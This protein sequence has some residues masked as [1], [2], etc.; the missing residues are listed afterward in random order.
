MKHDPRLGS[1]LVSRYDMRS[2][3][4]ILRPRILLAA[5]LAIGF[6]AGPAEAQRKIEGQRSSGRLYQNPAGQALG[7]GSVVHPDGNLGSN[8]LGQGD[9]LDSSLEVGSGGRN[10]R[11]PR[12][13]AY[14][15]QNLQARNLVVTNSVTGGRGFRGDVGYL[16]PGDFAGV[17]GDEATYAF[18][19][20]SALSSLNFL[21]SDRALDPFNIAQ[22]V[23]VFQYRRDFTSL[24]EVNTIDGIRRI[25]DAEIRL[26]R[27]NSALASRS[28]VSTAT[29]PEDIGIVAADESTRL[30]A[31][32]S[33][34]RGVQ[35]RL[36]GS[37]P[38]KDLYGEALMNGDRILLDQESIVPALEPFRSVGGESSSSVPPERI[39]AQLDSSEAYERIMQRVYE[40]YE[41]QEDVSIDAAS[42]K[43]MRRDFDQLESR[44]TPVRIG[45]PDATRPTNTTDRREG[46]PGERI[47]IPGMVELIAEEDGFD[48]ID[49]G[50][51]SEPP[52]DDDVAEGADEAGESMAEEEI[53]PRS[54]DELVRSLSHGTEIASVV[55]PKMSARIRQLAEQGEEAMRDGAYFRAEDRFTLALKLD[56]GNPILEAGQ[57]NAQIGAGLYRSAT[58]TLTFMYRRHPEMIDVEW[59]E[60]VRPTQTR[61]LLAADDIRRMIERDYEG[62]NGLGLLIAYIGRQL[63]D[64][65]LIVEGLDSIKDPRILS[66]V[67]KIRGIW[68]S[69]PD[70]EVDGAE[71]SQL[72]ESR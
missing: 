40:K 14:S 38:S 49:S 46:L 43:R 69:N 57:A 51:A 16:A 64:R 48:G 1:V 27:A 11:S 50:E 30:Q 42:L 18:D 60:S 13:N 24:P 21:S 54:I 35:Y 6:A 53:G 37:E 45:D 26:D 67:P 72:E 32:S 20:N 8:A 61:L 71:G 66:M 10:Y 29:S 31:S 33:T 36:F 17:T 5:L 47:P 3:L 70:L 4:L 44:L 28:L 41:G 22:G 25:D 62:S 39:E 52:T 7:N 55:D 58:V 59:S 2:D 65:A 19:R 68:L 56:R 34:I 15:Y 23:G 12:M 63:G 9:A